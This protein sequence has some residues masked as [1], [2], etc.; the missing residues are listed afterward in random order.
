L[1]ALVPGRDIFILEFVGARHEEAVDA[2]LGEPGA[3]GGEAALVG[4]AINR[5][6]RLVM[7]DLVLERH[8][9]GDQRRRGIGCD[10][11]GPGFRIA[12]LGRAQD[13]RNQRADLGDRVNGPRLDEQTR[14]NGIALIGQPTILL[15]HHSTVDFATCR[16]DCRRRE[17][18]A[19]R[20][21]AQEP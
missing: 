15:L 4:G 12:R 7:G 2:E 16:H 18:R 5:R 9:L 3:H 20:I 13:A 11:H 17:A 8:Q 14:Q 19:R 6:R 1:Q 21:A 10:Q